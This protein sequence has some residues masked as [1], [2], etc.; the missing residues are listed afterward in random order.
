MKDKLQS[1]VKY[2]RQTPVFQSLGISYL[3]GEQKL[4]R[5]PLYFLVHGIHLLFFCM[6]YIFYISVAEP[7]TSK[8]CFFLV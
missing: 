7:A 6:V 4:S 3:Y 5:F 2:V 8:V 1:W